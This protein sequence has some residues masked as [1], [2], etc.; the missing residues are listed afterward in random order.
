MDK[1]HK[2]G[3]EKT[4]ELLSSVAGE[5]KATAVLNFITPED[6]FSK[7][8]DKLIS[9]TG[10]RGNGSDRLENLKSLIDELHLGNIFYL[11]PSIARGLDYYT[12]LVFETYLTE[13]PQIGSIC[14]GGR[15]NNLASI[16]T[17]E[18]IPGVGSSIGLDRLH[19]AQKQLTLSKKQANNVLLII[20]FMNEQYLGYYHNISQHLRDTGV[21]VEVYPQKKKLSHQFQYAEK[22]GIPFALIC[23][24]E[25]RQQGMLTLKNLQ[26]RE[27]YT[28]LTLE[29]L[30]TRLR[31]STS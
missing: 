29:S 24:E 20:F 3:R 19:A 15:Y 21:S 25:E 11:D 30:K 12:S 28:D 16:Y 10:G 17:K 7:T 1:Q 13:L 18:N 27:S 8:M 14:S 22:K 26:T 6:S 23:G 9:E 31:T 2:L 5:T 4:G